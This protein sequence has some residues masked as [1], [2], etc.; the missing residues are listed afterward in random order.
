[1]FRFKHF[2]HFSLKVVLGVFRGALD[3]IT[4][5]GSLTEED[6]SCHTIAMCE[7]KNINLVIRS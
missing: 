5:E 6:W 7:L 4:A 1:M 2:Y 3:G